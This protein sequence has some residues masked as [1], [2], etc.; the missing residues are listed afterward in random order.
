MPLWTGQTLAARGPCQ[1]HPLLPSPRS[2]ACSSR[3]SRRCLATPTSFAN[4]SA[5][6]RAR[7]KAAAM[8]RRA[9]PPCS[10]PI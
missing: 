1:A 10:R 9:A 5:A 4:W 6:W 8:P 2:A 7:A 3:N